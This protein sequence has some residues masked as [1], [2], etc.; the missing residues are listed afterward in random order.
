MKV[1]HFL[2]PLQYVVTLF[3]FVEVAAF[4]G[5][6]AFP[7]V[8]LWLAVR[9]RWGS[10]DAM[11]VLLLTMVA[12]LGY[13]IYGVSLIVVLPIARWLTLS[14]GTPLGR[15]PYFSFR[16]YQWASYN[17]L[18]LVMR[19]SFMNWIRATPFLPLFHRLMGMRIGSR[20]QINTAVIADQNLI[21]IGDDTVVGGDVTLVAHSVERSYLV[22][23]PVKIGKRVTIGLM[24]VI[25]PG[26][27]IG[28]DAVI[29]A[30]AVLKK[31]TKIGPNEI[32]GGVP[33]QRV[34]SRDGHRKVDV[35]TN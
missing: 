3:L 8:W 25:M 34:G 16:G 28:D 9:D 33:A 24:A 11:H 27:E 31:G 13:F 17:A 7:G 14:L 32:W 20:V 15:Y 12:A 29:A 2:T 6:A 30:N 23:A 10:G 22:T 21:S 35:V 18:T 26:C 4:T 5:A 19:F 1:H